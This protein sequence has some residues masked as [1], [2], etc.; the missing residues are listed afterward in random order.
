M[1][2]VNP[3][4]DYADA[5]IKYWTE[6]CKEKHAMIGLKLHFAS[7]KVRLYSPHEKDQPKIRDHLSRLRRIYIYAR[8]HNFPVLTHLR[9]PFDEEPYGANHMKA[10][11]DEVIRPAA[12]VT[13]QIAHMSGYGGYDQETD[14]AVGA[15]IDA[16]KTNPDGLSNIYF[17]ISEV[18]KSSILCVPSDTQS[19]QSLLTRLLPVKRDHDKWYRNVK[20]RIN[21]IGRDKILYGSDWTN[22][23][24]PKEPHWPHPIFDDILQNFIE[25]LDLDDD[26]V[27][28]ICRNR[29]PYF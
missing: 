7:S 9:D 2:S 14:D 1:F 8:D 25:D 20:H 11:I 24:H 26:L 27:A 22:T 12:G 10:F 29:A 28:D 5:E 19:E 3:T 15:F 16:R 4:R 17:D 18:M 13:V 6:E 23:R 21:Q